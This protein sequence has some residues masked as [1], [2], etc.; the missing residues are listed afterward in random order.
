MSQHIS[1][2]AII[3]DTLCLS[4]SRAS[5]PLRTPRVLHLSAAHQGRSTSAY[6]VSRVA[7]CVPSDTQ[8]PLPPPTEASILAKSPTAKPKYVVLAFLIFKRNSF[9]VFWGEDTCTI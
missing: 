8:V 3:A 5:T 1:K 2:V 9:C 4:S 6:Q 7:S